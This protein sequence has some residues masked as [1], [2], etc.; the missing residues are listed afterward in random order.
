MPIRKILDPN[1]YTEVIAMSIRMNK[2]KNELTIEIDGSLDTFTAPEL[3]NRLDTVLE[4][5]DKLIF[6]F[7]QLEY[8]SSAGLRALISAV[9]IMSGRGE[10]VV[11]NVGPEVMDILEMAGFADK[12]NIE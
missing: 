7:S 9:K 1:L 4:G 5:I 8:I 2:N 12:L 3:E 11:R 10:L 6:E